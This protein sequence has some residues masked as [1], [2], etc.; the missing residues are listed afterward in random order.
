M[1][2][3]VSKVKENGVFKVKL[4]YLEKST[5]LEIDENTC[6]GCG[7]CTKICPTG[8][9]GRG[10]TG[11]AKKAFLEL[12]DII[13]TITDAEK[14]SYCGL[15][16]YM[17]PW[18]AI[19]LVI[20]D[21]K[22]PR[23]DLMLVTQKAVP[24]L[25]FVMKKCKEGVPEAKF[26]V[27]GN[28][29]FD[30]TKCPG[31]CDTCVDVCPTAALKIEKTKTPWD[32]GRKMIVDDDKCIRCGTCTNACPVFDAIKLNITAVKAKGDRND[33]LWDEVVKKI[34]ISRIRGGVKIN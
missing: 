28:I 34:K 4:Q 9:A 18:D 22:V 5:A 33:I 2:P 25:E 32:K 15:C 17:C 27:E 21:K 12:E 31:G 19:T 8:A 29:E 6:Q 23:E 24:D 3:R 14:C 30:M 10:P 1:F 20:D 11:A 16:V 26:F 7:L 13:P